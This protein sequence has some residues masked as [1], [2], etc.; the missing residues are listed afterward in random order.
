MELHI[1]AAGM[2]TAVGYNSQSSSAAMRAAISGVEAISFVDDRNELL[3]GAKVNL[4]Q[5]WDGYQKLVD[6]VSPAIGECLSNIPKELHANI[7]LLIGL[8]LMKLQGY[9]EADN[10]RLLA[11]IENKLALPHHPN[12]T[13][14][15]F[16]QVSGAKALKQAYELLNGQIEGHYCIVAGVDSYLQ[17]SKIDHYLEENRVITKKNS[18]GFFPGEAGS[19]VLVS[20]SAIDNQPSLT[21][22]GIGEA[23]E[24]A[25]INSGKVFKAQGMTNAIRSAVNSAGIDLNEATISLSDLNGEHY[26]FEEINLATGRFNKLG[27]GD[28]TVE[29]DMWHPI[30]FIGEVGAAIIPCLLGYAWT[31]AQ[32]GKLSNQYILVSAGNDKQDRAALIV[33]C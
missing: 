24:V 2:V 27:A 15:Y 10:A 28:N 13:L 3:F 16:G 9:P 33:E 1:I 17:Q 7:P 5:W 12:S 11:D 32:K 20:L 21:V 30:E 14:F 22:T 8:P 4:P 19:A 29:L 6:L 23:E 26:K 25:A 31:L 18:N